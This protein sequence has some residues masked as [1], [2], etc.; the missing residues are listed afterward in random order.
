MKIRREQPP[1]RFIDF[2]FR[3]LVADPLGHFRVAIERMGLPVTAADERA[4]ADWM[5][6]HTRDKHPPHEYRM[7]DYG[8]SAAMIR[9]E[10][11]FY[12]DAFVR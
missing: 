6:A 10:L 5:A 12:H 4:A 7:E 11:G 8:L 1:E 9:D 2:Q 3:E